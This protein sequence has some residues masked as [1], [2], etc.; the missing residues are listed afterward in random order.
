MRRY[1][2]I[3]PPPPWVRLIVPIFLLAMSA[4]ML[5]RRITWPGLREV[6]LVS[7]LALLFVVVVGL[8]LLVAWVPVGDDER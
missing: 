5:W 2:A 6:P 3:W 4:G 7:D 1:I 8:I